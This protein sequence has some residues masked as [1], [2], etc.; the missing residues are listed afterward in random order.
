MGKSNLKEK[1]STTWNNVVLHWK[2]PALGKYVSYKEIIAYGVGGMGV[3]FVM[4]F[5]SL[6]ALSAT[7]F[8]VGNTIGIKPMHLQYMAVASTI[9]GFGITI[10]RSYII[11]S[12]R[13]KSGK[14]RPW[15]AITGIPTVIIAVVFVWLPYETMSYMQKVIAVFLCYNLLQCFYPFFQQAY[16]DLANVISPNSHERTDIVSVSSIIYSMAPSLTGLFVPMLSTLTGGLNSITTYR[17]IHPLVAVV[18]LLLSYVAYAGTRERI[19]VAESHVTQF[20]FSDAFRAV[21]KNK[22]FWITSLAGWLGF[23]EGAVDVIVGWTFIYAYPDRMGLYGVATTLIGNAALWAMLICPIAIRVIGK[24]NLL[25]WCN[26]TNVVLIGLL[27]PLYNNIPALIILYY[28]NRFVNSFAIVYTPGINADMRDYQQYFTGERI[29]GMFGAVGIIGSFIGMFTGMVLPT[30]Y[31]MLGLEDNYDVLEVASF[32]EDMFDVLII[33]AAIGAALNFVPY[34]FYDLTETKQRGIVKVLKIR[35]MFEDYGNG[36]LRDESIV[37]AIDIIDEANLLYKDRTLMTTKDDIK[38]AERLPARTPEEKEFKKNEI[39]RLKAAYKE[40]NTQNRGIKKDRI[41]QAKAMPKSTDAEKAARKAAIKAAKKENRELNKLNADI[42]V[43][44]FI[45][46]EMNKYDTLRIKKQVERSR[47][48][49]A[50]G[51]AGIFYYSKEDMAEAKALPKSTHEEREIRSDAITHARALKNARKA[52][53]K[54]YGSPENIVEPSDDAFKAAEALPDDTFA[55]QLEKKR[56]VKKLVNEKSKYIRSVKPLLDARRQLTEK[57]IMRILTISAQDTLTQKR[58]P[59]PSTRRAESRSRDSKRSARQT[60]SAGSRSAWQR[61]TESEEQTMKKFSKIAAVVAL[62][63]VVCLSFTGCGNLGNAI[64]SAL[65]LDVTVDD[66]ALIKVEDILDKTVKTESVKSGDFTYTLYTDNT[67]CITGY[68]GSNPVV[69]IPAEIDG[70]KVVG[71]ENKALKSSSTLK[72]LI[73]PDSVEAIGNYA[74]MYCDNLEKVTIGKNVKHIGISAFEGSQENAYTGKSKLKTVIF[75]GAP[76]TISE[77]AFYF[78]S[79]L[80]EIVLPEGVETIG[81]W[82]FAKCFSAKKIIIPEG[83]TQIDDHAFLKCTGAVEISI[84]GTVESIAVSTFYRCSS[85]EKLSL[86]EGIKKLEKGAFEECSALKTVTLPESLEELGKYAFYNCT[87]LDEITIH[88]GV[89]V[90]GGEIFKDVGKLTISTES[91]S[92]A[93]KYAQDNGFDV[94]VIG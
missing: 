43:C 83:V 42:S 80:T 4:F 16:T 11:D 36:I 44:D 1:V 67:A 13:F 86:G 37:E 51:Y 90:F 66:P 56:T 41:N 65:S 55:H 34:L 82:A 22:Y 60:S 15:L 75:N 45:I 7:S 18:G 30:I 54:F 14:F 5:C 87:G 21:A 26:V 17:I 46:D 3:Q 63:L 91:G 93:E 64:I 85:L 59:T 49:E 77:K 23:L 20:K 68:T 61:R 40:F 31:Q 33:A 10:G 57:R 88:S 53:I 48:L 71:L 52:M 35:A 73:L 19:I 9:I 70:A 24:R 89:T 58:T 92:D 79:A 32:R 47:A 50:A 25:I 74:A 12:A 72:E 39:K 29:D 8:L 28:L 78:C 6:I 84:P 38:K 69:S 76:K 2:T 27:Y 62:M 81:E 94:A